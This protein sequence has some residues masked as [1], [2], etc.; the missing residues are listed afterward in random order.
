MSNKQQELKLTI[1]QAGYAAAMNN[2]PNRNGF[3]IELTHADIYFKGAKKTRIPVVGVNMGGKQ[4]RVRG[5]ITSNSEEYSYDEVRFIDHSDVE[6]CTLVRKDVSG[7]VLDFVAPHKMSV[8]SYNLVFTTLPD[9]QVTVVADTNAGWLIELTALQAAVD[10]LER[11]IQELNPSVKFTDIQ[12]KPTTLSG[13][14]ITDAASDEELKN[15][16]KLVEVPSGTVV[17]FAGA[18][19]PNGWLRANGAALSRTN[20]ASLFAA[21]GTIYGAGDGATTFN[22]P[23]LRG[24]FLR[25]LDSVRGVDG[26]RSLGSFQSDE[27]RS[28]THST[29]WGLYDESG[30]V[31]NSLGSG[32]G[33]KLE[34][35]FNLTVGNAGGSETRPRN[36]ALLGIIKI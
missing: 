29:N 2:A 23:D 12:E 33:R 32:G 8:L 26:G 25:V 34:T 3:R 24:E 30:F 19:P 14:G 17:Y 16:V 36:I 6:F 9:D 10:E 31:L 22:L 27:F 35:H 4:V 7:G 11:N 28:H 18:Q 5:E 13:Y 1:T 15:A 21:I 20:Y